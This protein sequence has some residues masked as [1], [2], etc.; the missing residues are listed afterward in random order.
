MVILIKFNESDKPA[1]FTTALE[2]KQY[3]VDNA[4]SLVKG[5]GEEATSSV[6]VAVFGE[7]TEDLDSVEF[8]EFDNI[9]SAKEFIDTEVEGLS[10]DKVAGEDGTASDDAG[11]S[12]ETA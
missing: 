1:E 2:A 6:F 12:E 3:L 10:E 4:G 7:P 8:S 5:E 9:D 11:E